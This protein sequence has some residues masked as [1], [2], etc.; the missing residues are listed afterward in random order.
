[1]STLRNM[2]Y[3]YSFG[4]KIAELDVSGIAFLNPECDGESGVHRIYDFILHNKMSS[5]LKPIT[6]SL[7]SFAKGIKDAGDTITLQAFLGSSNISISD[8]SSMYAQFSLKMYY[9]PKSS[10]TPWT[11]SFNNFN[12]R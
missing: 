7:I 1:M 12:F 9:M 6:L 10:S 3:L 4:D 5:T 8:P 11:D 2:T